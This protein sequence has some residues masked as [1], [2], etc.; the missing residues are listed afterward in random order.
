[1]RREG[2]VRRDGSVQA[3][4]R[5]PSGRSVPGMRR[6]GSAMSVHSAPR[7]SG[8]TIAY[9]KSSAQVSTGLGGLSSPRGSSKSKPS[10]PPGLKRA[11]SRKV[12]AKDDMDDAVFVRVDQDD[13]DYESAHT[14]F[15][16]LA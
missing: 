3:V 12:G 15:D 4:R 8:S 7:R 6:D 10:P 2:S 5:D 16:N 1:M 13:V 11:K 14:S 9:A